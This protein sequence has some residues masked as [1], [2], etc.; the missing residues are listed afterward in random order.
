MGTEVDDDLVISANQNCILSFDQI[1]C[2]PSSCLNCGKCVQVCPAKLSPV[3][4]MKNNQPYLESKK[5]VECGLCSYIC[6]AKINVR[7]FVRKAKR[8]D[9]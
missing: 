7:E 9:K 3:M 2:D 8:G 1:E 4:I 6:P 5:C